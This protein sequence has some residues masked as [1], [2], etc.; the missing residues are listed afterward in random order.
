MVLFIVRVNRVLAFAFRHGKKINGIAVWLEYHLDTSVV[1]TSGLTH[2]PHVNLPLQWYPHARQ[3]V[4][5]FPKHFEISQDTCS[6][7][8]IKYKV[9]FKPSTGEFD[10]DFKIESK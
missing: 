5:L 2:S 3:A 1:H 9:V 6:K 4:H 7:T 8:R 10:F